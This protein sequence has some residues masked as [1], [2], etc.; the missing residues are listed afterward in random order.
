MAKEVNNMFPFLKEVFALN[1]YATIAEDGIIAGDSTGFMDSGSY[2]LNAVL[3]GSIYGGYARNKITELAGESSVGK[4]F[5]ALSMIKL[6]LINNPD[7]GVFFFESESAISRQQLVDFGIDVKRVYMFPVDT[8]QKF[9]HQALAILTKYIAQKKE[10]RKPLLM[11]LDSLGMLSTEKEMSDIGEG[12]DTRDMTRAQLVKAA[13]RVITLKLGIASIP[14]IMTNHTYKEMGLFPKTIASGG[15]GRAYAAS[16]TVFLSKRKEKIGTDVVGNVI[17]VKMEK[18]RI[19]RENSKADTIIRY[20]TGLDRWYGMA[21]FAIE[22]GIW[23]KAGSRVEIHDGSKVYQKNIYEDTDKYFTPDV[24]KA[25]DEYVGRKFL[26]GSAFD[27]IIEDEEKF[28]IPKQE[29][30]DI[31]FFNQEESG[32]SA[33]SEV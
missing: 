12:K 28:I 4:S 31:D 7:G 32:A 9:R 13:F 33:D 8:V 27:D 25:I 21:D 6:F 14:L 24:M 1:E 23:K 10:D 2:S 26:Y 11:I 3:S 22:A 18:G 5:F 20:D 29:E 30:E 16:S 17:H 15:S 19:T